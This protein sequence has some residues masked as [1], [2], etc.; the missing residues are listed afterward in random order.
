M[1]H[2]SYNFLT[3]LYNAATTCSIKFHI[4]KDITLPEIEMPCK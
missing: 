4:P 2:A 1:A 3:M